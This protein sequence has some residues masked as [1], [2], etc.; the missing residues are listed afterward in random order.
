MLLYLLVSCAHVS[1]YE[2]ENLG[3]PCMQS[4]FSKSE[5][6]HDYSNKVLQ[7]ATAQELPGGTPGG[8]C[9]CTQ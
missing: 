8:G 7:T 2:R 4:P 3:R 1:R 9:G 6:Q 5:I